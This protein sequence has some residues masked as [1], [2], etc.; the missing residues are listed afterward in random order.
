MRIFT[1]LIQ[2]SLLSVCLVGFTGCDSASD[3]KSAE[4]HGEHEGHD[5]EGHD[6]H[7]HDHDHEGHDHAGHDHKGHI[8]AKD[9]GL[10]TDD[11]VSLDQP[12]VSENF[13]DAFGQLSEIVDTI[14]A[15]LEKGNIDEAHGPLHDIG[16][17]LE[18]VSESAKKS[19]MPD[20]AK[21]AIA[22][23]IDQLFDDFGAIDHKLHNSEKGK[24]YADVADSIKA[25]MKDL[26]G[27]VKE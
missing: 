2:L 21:K 12:E 3:M 19:S 18:G 10:S 27:Y 20:A 23:S 4:N 22:K 25:A 8:D 24:D 14:S 9:A 15:G 7:E 1:N 6:E 5:H 16:A 26:K 11:L 13:D 17:L